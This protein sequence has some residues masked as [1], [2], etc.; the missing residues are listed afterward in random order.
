[1]R[2]DKM[3]EEFTNRSFGKVGDTVVKL[4]VN[5]ADMV[6][7]SMM[8]ELQAVNDYVERAGKCEN[9]AVRKLL[10]DIAEEERTHFNEFEI[11]LESLDSGHE[12]GEEEG[13]K[14]MGDM[15]GEIE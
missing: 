14:E 6:R 3:M 11:M 2:F 5:D 15:F 7:K 1:M 13:E 9:E 10:L 8:E 4:S 12:K